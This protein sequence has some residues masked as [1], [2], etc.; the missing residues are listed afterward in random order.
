MK[1]PFFYILITHALLMNS[2][3][4]PPLMKVSGWKCSHLKC[5]FL[6]TRTF[7]FWTAAFF[8]S[9]DLWLTPNKKTFQRKVY[10][11]CSREHSIW[12]FLNFDFCWLQ[13]SEDLKFHYLQKV[14]Q[15]LVSSYILTSCPHQV[16]SIHHMY[17]LFL[18]KFFTGF[19]PLTLGHPRKQLSSLSQ[20]W[21]TLISPY[22]NTVCF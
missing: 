17:F 10:Q 19:S 1:I 12:H 15:N 8:L 9:T 20:L 3:R 6:I 11:I 5:V 21:T 18:R 4:Y 16:L 13:S 22:N 7:S 14:T 2:G